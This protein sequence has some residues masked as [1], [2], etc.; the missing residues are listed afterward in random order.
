MSQPRVIN[1]QGKVRDVGTVRFLRA[2]VPRGRSTSVAT[3]YYSVDA[4]DQALGLRLDVGK[5]SF[6][7]TTGIADVDEKLTEIAPLVLNAITDRLRL[8]VRPTPRQIDLLQNINLE[9]LFWL[10]DDSV[11]QSQG[12]MSYSPTDKL[13]IKL[14]NRLKNTPNPL[15]M[16]QFPLIHATFTDGGIATLIDCFVTKQRFGSGGEGTTEIL[17]NKCIVGIHAPDLESLKFSGFQLRLTSL[18]EWMQVPFIKQEQIQRTDTDPFTLRITYT[19][20]APLEFSVDDGALNVKFHS[21]FQSHHEMT[22][23]QISQTTTLQVQSA[24][25]RTL[26]DLLNIS[27]CF[28]TF[29]SL[30]VGEAVAVREMALEVAAVNVANLDDVVACPLIAVHKVSKFTPHIH[31]MEMLLPQLEIKS[32]IGELFGRWLILNGKARQAFAAFFETWFVPETPLALRFVSIVS[33]L[34]IFGRSV[35][36]PSDFSEQ[37]GDL[38]SRVNT[39]SVKLPNEI[40]G[41]LLG[42]S[43]NFLRTVVTTRNFIVHGTSA[44]E[45]EVLD[46]E[47]LYHAVEKLRIWFISLVFLEIGI[48]PERLADIFKRSG[49][50]R[51]AMEQSP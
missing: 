43:D 5:M 35:E 51:W 41:R 29:L 2:E 37:N 22:E 48:A 3:I 50:I 25:D 17:A 30:L 28:Q 49:W 32:S 10:P 42:S 4:N 15:E 8:Q 9:G 45:Q 23:F 16:S 44:K 38:F 40:R 6:L 21:G 31:P 20:P 46:G 26:E 1:L 36:M 19:R 11:S 12:I 13:R 47:K 18:E 33:A 27:G 24:T 14:S 7:D 34:E 39:L